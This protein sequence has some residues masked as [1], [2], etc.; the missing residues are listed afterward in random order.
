MKSQI[1]GVHPSM[2]HLPA[3]LPFSLTLEMNASPIKSL[4]PNSRVVLSIFPLEAEED[5]M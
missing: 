2:S 5:P 3:H 4:L 1:H